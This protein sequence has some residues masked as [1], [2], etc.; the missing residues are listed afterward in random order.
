MQPF[1]YTMHQFKK[2][3]LILDTELIAHCLNGSLKHQKLLYQKFCGMTMGVSMRYAKNRED[4]EDILQEAFIIIFQKLH[5]YQQKGQLGAWIRKITV[6]AALMHYRKNNKYALY[7]ELEE[8]GIDVASDIDIFSEIAAHDLM[9]HIQKLPSGYRVVFNLYGIEGYTH[10]EIAKELGIAE[11]TSK[12]Q[13][14]RARKMLIKM[15][16]TTEKKIVVNE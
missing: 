13:Y 6:N 1:Q 15:I 4:A 10:P 8:E 5:T 11:G 12:S 7:A 14:S 2:E 16:E 9:Q 3:R